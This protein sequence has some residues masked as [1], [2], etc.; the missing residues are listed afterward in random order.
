[1]GSEM[2]I[3]DSFNTLYSILKTLNVEIDDDTIE[4]LVKGSTTFLQVLQDEQSTDAA[5]EQKYEELDEMTLKEMLD[6]VGW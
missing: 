6:S 5:G 4:R 1:M 3:R 2:C